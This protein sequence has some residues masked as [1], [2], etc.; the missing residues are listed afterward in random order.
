M[1]SHTQS[2]LPCKAM[3]QFGF[4]GGL[5]LGSGSYGDVLMELKLS[6]NEANVRCHE[7]AGHLCRLLA[8]IGLLQPSAVSI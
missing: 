6:H 7:M 5:T 8:T 1:C 2:F 4:Q 3:W